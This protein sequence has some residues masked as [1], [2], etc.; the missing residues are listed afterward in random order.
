MAK[1]RKT[2]KRKRTRKQKGGYTN[3][4]AIQVFSVFGDQRISRELLSFYDTEFSGQITAGIWHMPSLNP[5]DY[6]FYVV[7]PPEGYQGDADY[8][9]TYGEYDTEEG[10]MPKPFPPSAPSRLSGLS[11]PLETPHGRFRAVIL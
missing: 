8:L 5:G 6:T 10:F 9:L 4:M 7:A 2:G 3:H 1:R 11:I